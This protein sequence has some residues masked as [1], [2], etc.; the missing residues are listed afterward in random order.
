MDTINQTSYNDL[1]ESLLAY[2]VKLEF[3][4]NMSDWFRRNRLAEN[5]PINT[6]RAKHLYLLNAV[7]ESLDT[8][9][10]RQAAF[11]CL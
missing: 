9:D 6:L 8:S 10:V 7:P 1:R 3:G 2:A 11:G 5:Q 4:N